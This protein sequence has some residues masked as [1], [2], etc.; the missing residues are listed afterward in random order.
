MQTIIKN[1]MVFNG[2]E[3][4]G[5]ENITF[6]DGVIINNDNDNAD[7]IIDGTGCTLLP[8]LIDSHIHLNEKNNL[9]LAA[10][11]GVTTMLD[12]MTDNTS[13]VNSVRN[14]EGLTD[15]RSCYSS[16]MSKPSIIM[17]K[18]LGEAPEFVETPEQARAFIDKQLAKGA[19]YVKLILENPPLTKG[20]LSVELIKVIVDYS[21]EKGKLVSAHCTSVKAY[22]RAAAAGVDVINHVPKDKPVSDETIQ[23]I[24]DKGLYVIPTMI[25]QEGL[26]DSIKKKM[27]FKRA[28][29]SVVED[30][31]RRMYNK[32]IPLIVGTDANHTNSMNYV[33]HGSSIHKELELLTRA[34]MT[35]REVLKAA[36]A[37]PAKVFNL[38]DRGSIEA[39]KRADLLLVKGNPIEDIEATKNIQNVWI[40]GV[41]VQDAGYTG[42]IKY[43]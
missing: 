11:N 23:M 18:V 42:G 33:T 40:N 10:R 41:E 34:G 43:E 7:K 5:P 31:V 21:H 35:T 22:D 3:M 13:L 30:T 6:K 25:M 20:M 28:K 36:T 1:V 8:G 19:D 24:K 14:L 2:M 27:P 16:I 12:M 17:K 38:E 32:G 29:Y 15:I 4:V 37:L 9:E 26:V 39:G